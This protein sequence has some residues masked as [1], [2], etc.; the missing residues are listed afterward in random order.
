MFSDLGAIDARGIINI[1]N[2]QFLVSSW[3]STISHLFLIE[4]NQNSLEINKLGKNKNS[5][6]GLKI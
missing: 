4:V 1:I 5:F 3:S 6:K 2:N